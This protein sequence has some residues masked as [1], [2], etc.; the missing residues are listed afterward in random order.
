MKGIMN[1]EYFRRLLPDTFRVS[2]SRTVDPTGLYDMLV[3]LFAKE[4]EHRPGD[5]YLAYGSN[6]KLIYHHLMTFDWCLPYL[7]QGGRVLDWGCNHGSD[8]CIINRVFGNSFE[9]YGCDYH[10]GTLFPNFFNAAA[11][12]Y[13]QLQDHI[14]LP[15][16]SASFDAVIG[17]GVLEHTAIDYASLQELYRIL[18]PQGVLFVTYLPN[19]YSVIEWFLEHVRHSDFHMRKYRLSSALR[20]LK[21]NGFFPKKWGYQSLFWEWRLAR[22]GIKRPGMLAKLLY[23]MFPI[24]R[25]GGCVQ[26]IANKVPSM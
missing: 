22:V 2:E 16:E 23:L 12:T 19:N 24:H 5:K 15:Y 14:K 4:M 3:D 21:H 26:I 6:P 10:D 20:L 11:M 9:R 7:P 18:K 8:A 25:M 13:Y 17:S 1:P